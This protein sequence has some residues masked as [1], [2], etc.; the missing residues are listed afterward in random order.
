MA[1]FTN[2]HEGAR[3]ILMKDGSHKIVDVGQ[4]VEVDEKDVVSVADGIEKGEKAAKEAAAD[5]RPA[6]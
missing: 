4:T 5:D 1:K 6:A 3:G 2:T